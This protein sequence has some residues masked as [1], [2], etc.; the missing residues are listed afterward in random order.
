M[1]T[2]R[3]YGGIYV[4]IDAIAK[5]PFGPLFSRSFLT[6]REVGWVRNSPMFRVLNKEEPPTA[7]LENS[8]LGFPAKSPFLDFW[9]AA[10]S[11][12]FPLHSATLFRTGPVLLKE[13]VLQ[14][15][16]PDTLSFIS[17][18]YLGRNSDLAIL[19]DEPGHSDWNDK[20]DVRLAKGGTEG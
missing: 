13:T 5:R 10:L 9:F 20:Q 16:Y 11:Q 3:R 12:N 6:L 8:P 1:G 4:D 19:V 7:G 18:E 17:W 15:P 2:V 14:F